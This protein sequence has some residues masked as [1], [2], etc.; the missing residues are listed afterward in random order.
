MFAVKVPLTIRQLVEGGAITKDVHLP[1]AH[2]AFAEEKHMA[3]AQSGAK[4]TM[5]I[6][7]YR[8]N[9]RT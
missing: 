3:R 6:F 2:A 5:Y 8:K 9:K 7:M 1:G 4:M